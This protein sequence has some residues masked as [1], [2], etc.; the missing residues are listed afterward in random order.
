M[1][2]RGQWERICNFMSE[3][4]LTIPSPPAASDNMQIENNSID[5]EVVITRFVAEAIERGIACAEAEEAAALEDQEILGPRDR[6]HYYEIVN[7]ELSQRKLVDQEIA[8]RQKEKKRSGRRRW[9]W[10]LMGLSI[11]IGASFVAYSY[12][13]HL[14]SLKSSDADSIDVSRVSH[15][16][17]T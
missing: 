16:H 6:L 9:M 12:I 11:A 3:A 4:G 8:R 1:V 13:P 14:S 15:S 2:M 7:H 5:Q 17:S 10:S